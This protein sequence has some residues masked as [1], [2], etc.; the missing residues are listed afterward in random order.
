MKVQRIQR[1]I[2]LV[3]FLVLQKII[4]RMIQIKVQG[5]FSIQ[6][7]IRCVALLML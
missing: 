5:I 4:M 7:K 2:I 6:Q 3:T 1:K